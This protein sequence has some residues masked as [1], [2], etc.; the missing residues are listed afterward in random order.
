M[1][2][3]EIRMKSGARMTNRRPTS[4]WGFRHS[5]FIRISGFVIL[6]FARLALAD[7]PKPKVAVFPLGGTATAEQREKVGFSLRA[8][9]DR[10]GTYAVIDGP[11]MI[12]LT[13]EQV[14]AFDT[15][16]DVADKLSK[17]EKPE[18]LIWGELNT[19]NQG[20]SLKIRVFDQRQFDPLPHA[21]EKAIRQPTDMRFVVEEILQTL[22]GMKTFEHPNEVAVQHDATAEKLWE[23]NP[24]LVTN[25]TFDV[26]DH[27]AG[28]LG[29]DKYT[30]KFSDALPDRDKVVIYRMPINGEHPNNVLA[31]NL[32]KGTAES[33]GLACLGD[34]IKIEPKTRYRVSFRYKSD[35]PKL[36]VFIKGYTTGKNIKG[37]TVERECYRRQV[38]P[39]GKTDGEWVTVVDEMNPQ[40]SV[41]PVE[42]LRVDLYAYLQEGVVMFDDITL[43][44]V[45]AQNRIAKDAAI[46]P[47]ASMPWKKD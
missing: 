2:K 20:T 12:D 15:K 1:M 30:V 19:A 21:F 16:L 32:S 46:K 42:F 31:M 5:S 3:P 36:H 47:P 7:D 8:K 29:P 44:A 40:H 4:S 37:E 14:L 39:T 26:A 28:L 9:L 27:W 6:V 24:N 13:G 34:A 33:Y 17:D 23:T 38:P 43:K 22:D 41:F 11:T 10:D 45:G 35:G 18:V 25:G